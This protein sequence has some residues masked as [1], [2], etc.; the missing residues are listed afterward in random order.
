MISVVYLFKLISLSPAPVFHKLHGQL[1]LQYPRKDKYK[2][3]KRKSGKSA[4]NTNE[5]ATV[6][7]WAGSTMILKGTY[8]FNLIF[9]GKYDVK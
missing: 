8:L 9:L 2:N 4:L 1:R 3:Y 7:T 6:N 5:S